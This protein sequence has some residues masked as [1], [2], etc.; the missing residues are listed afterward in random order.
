MYISRWQAHPD[1]VMAHK[2]KAHV[3]TSKR[4][5]KVLALP[6]PFIDTVHAECF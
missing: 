1:S 4:R 2:L 5:A 6:S 3:V